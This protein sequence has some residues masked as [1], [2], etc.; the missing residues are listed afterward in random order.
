MRSFKAARQEE[1]TE[2]FEFIYSDHEDKEYK[3][4]FT[5]HLPVPDVLLMETSNTTVDQNTVAFRGV[6][7]A[8]LRDDF[9]EFWK[10]VQ[11]PDYLIAA[12]SIGDIYAWFVED[13]SGRPTPPSGSS[14]D[15]RSS[16]G[17]SSTAASPS[18]EPVTL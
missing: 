14:S 17:T 13:A 15:G 11:S 1:R 10:I 5:A 18:P 12:E 16:T 4:V 7:Q 6:F 2:D 8:A 3:R 9:D